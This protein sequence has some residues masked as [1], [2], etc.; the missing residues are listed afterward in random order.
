MT[1]KDLLQ[2][3]LTDKTA[4]QARLNLM[5]EQLQ[6][7]DIDLAGSKIG[8]WFGST[9]LWTKRIV[10]LIFGWGFLIIA[11]LCIFFPELITETKEFKELN[12]AAEQ[13]GK[14]LIRIGFTLLFFLGLFLLYISRLTHKMRIRN[15]KISEAQTL[16]Q[17]I[18]VNF[19][20]EIKSSELDVQIIRE[21]VNEDR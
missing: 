14:V 2:K 6:E 12:I 13:V 11:L 10:S 5:S 20:E 16:A 21:I 3:L 7:L 18:I 1:T 15:L 17:S 19:Q 9:Y 8:R 4:R